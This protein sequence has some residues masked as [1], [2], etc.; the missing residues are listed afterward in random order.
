MRPLRQRLSI[1]FSRRSGAIGNSRRRHHDPGFDQPL[2]ILPFDR[3]IGR[4]PTVHNSW[5]ARKNCRRCARPCWITARTSDKQARQRRSWP[6]SLASQYPAMMS[7]T[8]QI[9]VP[10]DATLRGGRGQTCSRA[11]WGHSLNAM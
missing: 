8:D 1:D 6:F 11:E 9:A 4:T 2:C 5:L 7:K 10:T 3:Q